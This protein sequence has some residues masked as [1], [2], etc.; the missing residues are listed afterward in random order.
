MSECASRG[1]D[2]WNFCGFRMPAQDRVA[3][4][5]SI[6][7]L[8]WEK[9]LVRKH[10]VEGDAS[11]AL[12]ENHPIATD[13]LRLLGTKLQDVVIEYTQRLDQRHCR[14]DVA[15]FALV[16][17]TNRQSA[18]ILG[19][20]VKRYANRWRKIG[21]Y[22]HSVPSPPSSASTA[23]AARNCRSLTCCQSSVSPAR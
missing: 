13:P 14:S 17:R 3:M 18:E 16:K 7:L 10:H 23:R 20:F 1:F 11:V 4:A 5:K 15:T 2:A 6:Q 21:E 22:G 12:A 19:T 9:V 8:H